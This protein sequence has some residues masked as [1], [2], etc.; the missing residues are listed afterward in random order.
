MILMI[1][2]MP[3]SVG[4]IFM[5]NCICVTVHLLLI[6]GSVEYAEK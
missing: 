5:D 2:Q 1:R 3:E 4:I 6:T